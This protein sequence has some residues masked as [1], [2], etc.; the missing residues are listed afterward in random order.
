[1]NGTNQKRGNHMTSTELLRDF[2]RSY[3][4]MKWH[5]FGRLT[6]DRKTIPLW[7]ANR[8]FDRWIH[9]VLDDD[10]DLSFR[11]LRVTEYRAHGV[12]LRFHVFFRSSRMTSKYVWMAHWKDLVSGEADIAYSFTSKGPKQYLETAVYPDSEFE[13]K[14]DYQN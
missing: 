5:W 1:M 11:W 2:E 6:F 10:C 9:D 14:G 8:A 13:I 7:M 3:V 4:G 12:N